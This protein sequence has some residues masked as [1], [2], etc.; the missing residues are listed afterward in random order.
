M[1]NELAP[2]LFLF[3]AVLLIFG[4]T[5]VARHR[6]L[7][8]A[9]GCG[10]ALCIIA[11][12]IGLSPPT[13]RAGWAGG[14]GGDRLLTSARI[15][16]ISGMLF[17]AGTRFDFGGTARR[18]GLLVKAVI[19][20]G[21]LL[22]VAMLLAKWIGM[23]SIP[24]LVVAVAVLASS[25]WI[26]AELARFKKSENDALPTWQTMALA[27]TGFAVSVIYFFDVLS[28]TNRTQLS[29]FTYVIIVLFEVVKLFVLFGFAYFICSKFLARARGRISTTRTTIGF[30]LISVLVFILIAITTNQLA[31]FAWAFVAGALWQQS[32][33]GRKFGDAYRP[34]ASAM[35]MS[36]AFAPLM[37]Q[38]HGRDFRG[39]GFLALFVVIAVFAK[40]FLAWFLTQ[41]GSPLPTRGRL[42][43][44]LA[45]PGE[46]AIGILGFAITRWPIAGSPYFAVLGYAIISTVLIPVM[47]TETAIVNNEGV[48][49]R[50]SAMQKHIGKVL[51]VAVLL[52]MVISG[53][54]ITSS[55][56]QTPND[57]PNQ[58]IELGRGM[59]AM[60][61]GLMEIGS[62]TKLFLVFGDK[63]QLST[64]QR[65]GL[66]DLYVR[67][68]TY[69]FQREADL[70]VAD[71]ELKR[72]LTRDTVD[73]GA[74][75]AKMKEIETIRVE[76]NMKKIET[77]LQ[78][79]NALTH[80]QHT[81]IVLLARDLEEASKPRAP[82]YQ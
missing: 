52:L 39:L 40:G 29:V 10:V 8:E 18:I 7:P 21:V 66:E 74:V 28:I 43:I 55:A 59:S 58:Q 82:I 78:A 19:V 33:S 72:L 75:K 35:L 34:L 9:L 77:L 4:S 61:P 15:V 25:L 36:L 56:Q 16:G 68:Q 48:A 31:A 81:Q 41:S 71:A 5:R 37:L 51:A 80:E 79:I 46:I 57:P 70:D 26:P 32:E 63:L 24:T 6:G 2:A 11:I 69:S 1:I 20:A 60:T 22:V 49:R 13:W 45:F 62:K 76:V 27:F 65:K 30:V 67:I 17:I 53:T 54:A 47:W 44:S 12:A 3:I 73:L 64:E 14:P 50:R 23:E 42:A 38:T